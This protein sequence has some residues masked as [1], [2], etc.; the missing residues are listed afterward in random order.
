MHE[1]FISY[2]RHDAPAANALA[3]TL[4]G[5]GLTVWLDR[6][7]IQEGDAFDTQIE[8]A[9][10]QTRVV[11]VIW[12]K[13]FGEIALGARRGGL[14][15]R[16]AQAAADHD[17]PERA[18]AAIPADP[19]HRLPLLGP[20]HRAL[21]VSTADGR[22]HQAVGARQPAASGSDR[23]RRHAADE[24]GRA[25]GRGQILA[26]GRAAPL[27]REGGPALCGKRRRD[28]DSI[29]TTFSAKRRPPFASQWCSTPCSENWPRPR[30]CRSR[31]GRAS[32]LAVAP[33]CSGL[34]RSNHL[35]MAAVR[36]SVL[37]SIAEVDALDLQ[38][39]QRRLA[40]VDRDRRRLVLAEC[41]GRTECDFHRFLSDQMSR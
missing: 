20:Q 6:N 2:S 11:I 39:L 38:E 27:A 32:A 8:E 21:R 26:A 4:S 12:S 23:E 36:C 1:V 22:H 9:I 13:E 7:A 40:L 25:R 29:S 35:V 41:V 28:G 16:Q 37:R 31:L 14:R 24:T 30:P 15:T 10:A 18:A 3:D 5:A 19:E 17:R 34:A 33:T